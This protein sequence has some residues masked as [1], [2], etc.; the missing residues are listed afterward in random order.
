M[1]QA[2]A[3]MN[4]VVHCEFNKQTITIK[5]FCVLITRIQIYAQNLQYQKAS[6]HRNP[7]VAPMNN[8]ANLGTADQISDMED[9]LTEKIVVIINNSNRSSSRHM[10]IFKSFSFHLLCSHTCQPKPSHISST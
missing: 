1:L 6:P 7:Q 8:R 3:L 5:Y 2:S 9:E 4:S 10:A